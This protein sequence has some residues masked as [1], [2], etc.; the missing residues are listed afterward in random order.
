VGPREVV[1]KHMCFQTSKENLY[2]P[3]SLT[4]HKG[5]QKS[6]FDFHHLQRKKV[7][8]RKTPRNKTR[9]LFMMLKRKM[10]MK[11]LKLY[12]ENQGIIEENERLRR[13]A[14]VLHQENQLLLSQLQNV[15][16]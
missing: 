4:P 13:K 10:T 8:G 11:N 5:I 14:F 2:H 3:S 6:S 16:N 15:N 12:I 7:M 1:V 9:V